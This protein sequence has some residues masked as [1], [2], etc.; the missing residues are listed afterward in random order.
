MIEQRRERA[1]KPFAPLG[2]MADD[3]KKA[4]LPGEFQYDEL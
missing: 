1:N 4:F 2:I 3:R